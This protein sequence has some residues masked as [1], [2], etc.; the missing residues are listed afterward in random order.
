M[1]DVAPEGANIQ[2]SLL[3][4]FCDAMDAAVLVIDKSDCLIFASKRLLKFFAL[5]QDR[6]RPGTRLRDLLGS[7][8]EHGLNAGPMTDVL[9][10]GLSREEW[11]AERIAFH[12]RERHEVR[13]QIGRER[14][15]RIINRRL[16]SGI[17]LAAFIDLSDHVKREI[18]WQG[19]SER[20]KLTEDILDGLPAP[21]FVQDANLNFVAVNKAFCKLQ[22]TTAD[23]LLGRSIWDIFAPDLAREHENASRQQLLTG[24]SRNT[25]LSMHRPDGKE[26][27][28]LASSARIGRPGHFY[29][30]HVFSGVTVH[31]ESA[32]DDADPPVTDGLSHL[33]EPRAPEPAIAQSPATG[34]QQETERPDIRS[35]HARR[36]V[37]MSR[38]AAAG[39]NLVAAIKAM[40]HD[41]CAINDHL[42]LRDFLHA[43]RQ[44]GLVIDSILI[45]P[46][47][48]LPADRHPFA[49]L[50]GLANLHGIPCRDAPLGRDGEI[51]I[52]ALASLFSGRR[53]SVIPPPLSPA[54]ASLL[55]AA[56]PLPETPRSS[57]ERQ[58]HVDGRL[59]DDFDVLVVEDNKINRFAFQQ[60]L[61]SLGISHR[62]VAT[63]A[64]AVGAFR[65]RKPGLFLIDLTLPDMDGCA[66]AQF[67]RHEDPGA[68][69]PF[70]GV[71]CHLGED[72]RHRAL[73]A[74]MNATLVKPISPDAI[75]AVIRRLVFGEVSGTR[76]AL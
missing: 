31:V 61:E 65:A 30:A 76:K 44:A 14:W 70:V 49:E 69:T 35:D 10:G 15:I 57:G 13:R 29:L 53:L 54:P 22:A 62:I 32:A 48:L 18:S 6:L 25:L 58:G 5:P 23:S 43:A 50:P 73:A 60:I 45:D 42:E 46:P 9:L 71:L 59:A 75:D 67:L 41:S 36:V 63:A 26:L 2:A 24:H 72:D 38:D 17:G 34:L 27:S 3:D 40:G 19:D 39:E 20:V 68:A 66:L 1:D 51:R 33:Q 56:P 37:V 12:W 55:P 7:M 47:P 16:P 74:G 21:V 52:E 64:E 4:L 11:I 8:Y 28:L